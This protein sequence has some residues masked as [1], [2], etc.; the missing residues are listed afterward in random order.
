MLYPME[1]FCKSFPQGDFD[2]GQRNGTAVRESRVSDV[3]RRGDPTGTQRASI[4]QMERPDDS[5]ILLDLIVE[6]L[7]GEIRPK[8]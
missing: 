1:D 5:A 3:G 2:L 7:P 6:D 8:E 4:R